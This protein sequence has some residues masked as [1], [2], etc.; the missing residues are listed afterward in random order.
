M[1][2]AI[3]SRSLSDGARGW[4]ALEEENGWGEEDLLTRSSRS[5]SAQMRTSWSMGDIAP[6]RDRSNWAL[7]WN[8]LSL[9][10]SRAW[11]RVGV[12]ASELYS[13]ECSSSLFTLSSSL[14]F[15]PFLS[16]RSWSWSLVSFS[17]LFALWRNWFSFSRA[18]SQTWN[19]SFRS[20]ICSV[21][22]SSSRLMWSARWV[23]TFS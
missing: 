4:Y 1:F 22:L 17:S 15:S 2:R 18:L 19:L 3:L 23:V 14:S 5:L 21:A 7:L 11:V 12:F 8:V 20:W 6:I 10:S 13:R 9:A 16:W